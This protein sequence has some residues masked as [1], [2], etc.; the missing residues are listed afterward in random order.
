MTDDAAAADLPIL[1]A[2][3][4]SAVSDRLLAAMQDR[5]IADMRPSFGYVIR[6]VAAERPTVNGLAERLGVTK[7]SASRLVDDME[8]D[9]F[10]ERVVDPADRRARRLQLTDK[11][12]TV[13]GIAIAT[14]T[15][16]EAELRDVLDASAVVAARAVLEAII[17]AGGA[18]ADL[19]ARRARPTW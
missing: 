12:A 18:R 11:G 16:I 15:A 5:G 6:A 1:L 13:R 4:M 7:Q 19:A 10:V 8:R 2:G 3:A 9:G 17:T 14:G